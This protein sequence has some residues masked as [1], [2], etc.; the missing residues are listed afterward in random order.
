MAAQKEASEEIQAASKLTGDRIRSLSMGQ[1]AHTRIPRALKVRIKKPQIFLHLKACL[2]AAS[3][4][5]KRS[6]KPAAGATSLTEFNARF[7]SA[8]AVQE[9]HVR[10]WAFNRRSCSRLRVWL[11]RSQ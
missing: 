3:R 2:F 8:I 5:W 7:T 9:E 11:S 4:T 10:R 1:A 6:E